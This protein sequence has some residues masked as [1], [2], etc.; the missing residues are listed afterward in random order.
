MKIET[1]KNFAPSKIN[2]ASAAKSSGDSI[3]TDGADES[4]SQTNNFA[5]VLEGLGNKSKNSQSKAPDLAKPKERSDKSD[6]KSDGKSNTKLRS[7]KQPLEDQTDGEKLKDEQPRD[8]AA[9]ASH[10]RGGNIE[11]S[12]VEPETSIPPARSILHIADLERI[13]SGI[14]SSTFENGSQIE[15][16]LKNSVF[17][18]LKI[19]LR[20]DENRRVTAEFVAANDKIKGQIDARSSELADV[21]KQRGVKLNGLQTSVGAETSGDGGNHKDAYQNL[22]AINVFGKSKIDRN[23]I[24]ADTAETVEPVETNEKAGHTYRV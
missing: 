13:V 1:T 18:G 17:D 5:S 20:T 6:V 8:D 14:R 2:S 3:N 12:A 15:I 11:N 10:A 21:L 7:D 9:A 16:T 22:A 4:G 19:K 23:G 24:A